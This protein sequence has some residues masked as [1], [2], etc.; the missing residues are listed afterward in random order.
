MREDVEVWQRVFNWGRHG[1]DGKEVF[2]DWGR[3]VGF[4]HEFD[5]RFHRWAQM[6]GGGLGLWF[7][8]HGWHRWARMRWD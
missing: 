3:R 4:N 8:D 5:H 7:F 2:G 6:R 1:I